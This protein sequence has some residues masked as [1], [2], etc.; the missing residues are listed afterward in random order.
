M[1]IRSLMSLHDALRA[2]GAQLQVPA[3]QDREPEPDGFP[4]AKPIALFIDYLKIRVG[5]AHPQRVISIRV[6]VIALM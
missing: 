2:G 3:G 1:E 5:M 4:A 6:R